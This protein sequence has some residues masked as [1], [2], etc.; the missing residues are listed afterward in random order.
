MALVQNKKG[1]ALRNAPITVSGGV[2][3]DVSQPAGSRTPRVTYSTPG[4]CRSSPQAVLL[5]IGAAGAFGWL[6]AHLQ[7]PVML[8]DLLK[9]LTEN[10]S[11]MRLLVILMLLMLET[12][13]DMAPRIIICTPIFLPVIKAFGVDPVHCGVILLL[14]CGIG[15][16]TPPVGSVLF[17]GSG[18]GRIPMTQAL[19]TIWPFYIAC[20]VVLFLVAFV[21]LLSLWSPS[22]M[23]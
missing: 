23:H 17:V 2:R 10:P 8:V 18:I 11:V 15:L 5:I 6:M 9:G 12:F 1:K 7:V 4:G 14:S 19:K 22:L 13:M 21:P 20:V 16:I 3:K